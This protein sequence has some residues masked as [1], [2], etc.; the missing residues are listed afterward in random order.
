MEYLKESDPQAWCFIV[1][2][3][4]RDT[5]GVMVFAKHQQAKRD[6]QQ[7]FHDREVHR[8]YRA[9]VEAH[10]S[11]RHGEQ[12]ADGGQAPERQS[13]EQIT[14]PGVEGD[15]PLSYVD[16]VIGNLPG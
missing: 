13:R 2:R 14:S 6:L 5:S 7:Q 12:L 3:L 4:D 9:L 11:R 16:L 1:H 15:H 8:T 10:P